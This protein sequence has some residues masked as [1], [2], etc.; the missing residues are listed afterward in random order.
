[1]AG[2]LLAAHGITSMGRYLA[3][4]GD[5]R[6]FTVAERDELF[7]HDISVWLIR[8][9]HGGEVFDGWGMGQH[10]GQIAALEADVLDWPDH[11][12]VY[13][14]AD[15]LV[16]PRQYH[17]TV[18]YLQGFRSGLAGRLKMGIYGGADYV[19]W[20]QGQGLTDYQWVAG[21]ASWNNGLAPNLA[22]AEIHQ[23]PDQIL[24]GSVDLGETFA[25]DWGAWH[26][27]KQEGPVMAEDIATQLATLAKLMDIR[28]REE[29]DRIISTLRAPAP[30]EGQSQPP[31]TL[32]G[33]GEGIDRVREDLRALRESDK[34]SVPG[35]PIPSAPVQ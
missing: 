27:R 8:E 15:M 32:Q 29:G 2:A 28:V 18:P 26:P 25:L 30:A 7:A 20:T 12:P 13:A 24:N 4:S 21:A 3:R 10:Q 31:F 5:W 34:E 6:R 11:R 16:M 33:L 9:D 22:E 17:Q 14:A 35:P 1:V 19:R 23:F